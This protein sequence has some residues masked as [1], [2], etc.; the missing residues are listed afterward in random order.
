M[1]WGLS[2]HHPQFALQFTRMLT[3]LQAFC[4]HPL[5]CPALCP[6][7][8]SSWGQHEPGVGKPGWAPASPARWHP[9][10]PP[11][12]TVTGGTL[13]VDATLLS[14]SLHCHWQLLSNA[15][16]ELAT[17]VLCKRRN[18][19]LKANKERSPPRAAPPA[20]WLGGA[21]TPASSGSARH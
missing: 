2:P 5:C 12:R 1:L 3:H 20:A 18:N 4:P 11:S 9:C 8:F 6:S 17:V 19:S 13:T 7:C 16:A 15:K 21:A 10:Y 14:K